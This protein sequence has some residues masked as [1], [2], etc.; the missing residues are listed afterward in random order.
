MTLLTLTTARKR[1]VRNGALALAALT[2]LAG[3][4]SYGGPREGIGALGGAVA[5]G[6]LGSQIG[7]GSGQVLATVGGAVLGGLLGAELGRQL[8]AQ[9][10]RAYYDAQFRALESGR[11]GAP[12]VWQA[13][14]GTRGQVIPGQPYQI[15]ATVCRDYQHTVYIDGRPEVVT[16]TA[17]R[18]ADGSWRNV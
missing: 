12:V 8:D 16:G 14:S 2:A 18:Q 1:T 3:C 10:Q 13:P 11:A 15:N 5:G 7:A 4:Q 17:C 6:V 9:A